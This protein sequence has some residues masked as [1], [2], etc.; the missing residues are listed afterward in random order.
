MKKQSTPQEPKYF[1]YQFSPLMI[2]LAIAAMLLSVAGI[3]VSV[4]RIIKFGIREFSDALTN[5]FLILICLFCIVLMISILAKSQYI[6]DGTHYTTQ[7]G[8]IKSSFLIAD[9]TAIVLDSDTKKLTVYVGEEFTVLSLNEAWNEEFVRAL[10]DAN[11]EIE[12]SFT[13]AENKDKD[14]K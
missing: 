8:F 5:P 4:F 12:Y 13:L 3:V 9:I 1:K 14:E 2:V 10:L 7:F 6:V 11:P